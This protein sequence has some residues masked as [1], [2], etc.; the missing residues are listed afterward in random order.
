MREKEKVQSAAFIGGGESRGDAGFEV[1]H[2]ER[3]TA[4]STS[5][6]SSE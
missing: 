4:E 1:M 2:M 5:S 3:R 6:A